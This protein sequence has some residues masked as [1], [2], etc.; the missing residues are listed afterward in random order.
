MSRKV[1]SFVIAL[2]RRSIFNDPPRSLIYIFYLIENSIFRISQAV[3]YLKDNKTTLRN[4]MESSG[5]GYRGS[6]KTAGTF[7]RELIRVCEPATSGTTGRYIRSGTKTFFQ[8]IDG[9]YTGTRYD[10]DESRGEFRE[11]T[12]GSGDYGKVEIAMYEE[13][14]PSTYS[15]DEQKYIM[16][17]SYWLYEKSHT[18]T[19]INEKDAPVPTSVSL[20]LLPAISCAMLGCGGIGGVLLGRRRDDD[21]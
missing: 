5:S 19:H 1:Q 15:G 16:T 21:E 3:V 12:D 14:D 18:I 2:I 17:S 13:I 20:G 6:I 10:Y 11:S 8:K 7:T 9:S 4:N